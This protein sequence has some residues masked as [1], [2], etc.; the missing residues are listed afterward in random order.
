MKRRFEGQ[1]AIVTGAACGIGFAIARQLVA[2]GAK[3]VLNDLEDAAAAAAARELCSDGSVCYP[4]AGDASDPSF[5]ESL[6]DAAVQR[7]GRLDM[8]VANAGLTRFNRFLDTEV[9]ELRRMLDL[10]LQGSVFLAKFAARQMVEQG[11]GGRIVFLSSVAGH[12]AHDGVVCYGMTKAALRMLAKGLVVELAPYG[13]TTNAVSPGAT[14]TERTVEGDPD[15]GKKWSSKIPTGKASI[16][17]DIAN[18][19]LFL[20]SPEAAQISG[21]T[22]VVD[23]GWSATSEV[24][25]MGP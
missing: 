10:N 6:V 23:G 4:F 8:A 21:Q 9:V 16:P 7:F 19:A 2:E 3:V 17:A 22:L 11:E 14:L 25:E 18:A 12:Q 24:P 1:A 15:Y 13:I 20:L 5:L